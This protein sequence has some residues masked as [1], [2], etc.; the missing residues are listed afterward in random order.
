MS[1]LSRRPPSPSGSSVASGASPAKSLRSTSGGPTSARPSTASKTFEGMTVNEVVSYVQK[2]HI[3]WD[4][5]IRE[6]ARVEAK[7]KQ[8]MS[9]TKSNAS[10]VSCYSVAKSVASNATSASRKG[11]LG[12]LPLRGDVRPVVGI[13]ETDGFELSGLL[14]V[15]S[16]ARVVASSSSAAAPAA[17]SAH[18]PS[19]ALLPPGL[20]LAPPAS[21]AIAGQTPPRFQHTFLTASSAGATRT[22]V[23]AQPMQ[24]QQQQHLLLQ[25]LGSNTRSASA[26]S[27]ASRT[28]Q[29]SNQLQ[30]QSSATMNRRGAA[31]SSAAP[32]SMLVKGQQQQQAQPD[33]R[34]LSVS[35]AATFQFVQPGAASGSGGVGRV[36][37]LNLPHLQG[38]AAPSPPVMMMQAARPSAPLRQ[39]ASSV[40]KK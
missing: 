23:V 30:Q 32:A 31:P 25:S 29:R 39:A 13:G 10:T 14:T 7:A 22:S 24:Q 16:S 2:T 36:G 26:N 8:S 27:T 28:S 11:R 19:S 12:M 6:M 38:V 34:G 37:G 17:A 40:K 20:P 5:A 3:P 21:P 33:L 15:H 4:S 35:G 18:A 1:S 9:D